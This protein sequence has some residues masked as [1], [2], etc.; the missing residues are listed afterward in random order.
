MTERY[1][2]LVI[3]GGIAGLSFALEVADSGTVAVLT[4]RGSTESNTHYAQG[5]IAAVI[6]AEDAFDV[7]VR[8]TIV[9]GDGLNN[10]EI[11]EICVRE[12]PAAIRRLTERGVRFAQ[13]LG[14]EGGHT[15]RR[16]LHATDV[17]GRE[18]Q[19]ALTERAQAHPNIRMLENHVGIDLIR[20]R[21]VDGGHGPDRIVGAY[22]LEADTGRVST[23]AARVVMLATGGSG[24]VYLYT[25]N[26]DV[27][28]GDGVAMAWRARARIANMEFFQFHPTCLYHPEAKSFL[29]SEALRGEG[30]VLRRVDGTPFMDGVHPLGSL[31]PRDIVARAID[32][33]LKRTGDDHVVLDMTGLDPAYLDDRF[34]TILGRC[35]ALG[36]DFRTQPIP[37]VPAA[38]YQCGGVVVDRDGRTS[39]AGL[40]AAGETSCTGLH[41]ANR[42]ASNSLLEG[43]VF[44]FRAALAA[45]EEAATVELPESLPEWSSGYAQ[46]GDEDVVVSQ[47]WDEI[48]RFM[49]NYVGIVRSNR[50]LLRARRRLGLLSSEINED[51]WKYHVSRDSIELRNI[52]LVAELIIEGALRRQESRGLHY[53]LDFPLRDDAGGPRDTILWR[54]SRS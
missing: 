13:D 6:G 53:S 18:I 36:I 9:A 35:Q 11:V 1:D 34:P 46:P 28:T 52:A 41:G 43:A 4:K 45:R 19:R 17:T 12:G 14:R 40:Y 22:V 47:S 7:H 49:W 26:P 3:G 5:G 44:G 27:A 23:L 42:L 54:G 20:R 21:K 8:D 10:P 37:V 39:V 33:E 50:R 16:V 15:Y 29:I 25:T 48:R 31:A 24:K 38:H 2:F 32:A 30:G 51:W